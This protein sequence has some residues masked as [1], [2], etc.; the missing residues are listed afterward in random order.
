MVC[1][2][3]HW[4]VSCSF[5]FWKKS[6][7]KTVV[8]GETVPVCLLSFVNYFVVTKA[9]NEISR[10][11]L[12]EISISEAA[13]KQF[14]GTGGS[15]LTRV[16]MY[17]TKLLEAHPPTISANQRQEHFQPYDAETIEDVSRVTLS[18]VL[19]NFS[20]NKQQVYMLLH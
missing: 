16:G 4:A 14:K 9:N 19:L 13:I 8:F 15:R 6:Q 17:R 5:C 12:A 20:L 18:P 7:D 1:S 11:P 3:F 10:D 2:T